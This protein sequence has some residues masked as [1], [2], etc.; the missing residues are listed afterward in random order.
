MPKNWAAHRRAIKWILNNKGNS[1]T[2]NK[3]S[4]SEC[5]AGN[6]QLAILF[7]IPTVKKPLKSKSK[8]F[9]AS[10]RTCGVL[11]FLLQHIVVIHIF[12]LLLQWTSRLRLPLAVLHRHH[13]EA[14]GHFYTMCFLSVATLLSP[15]LLLLLLFFL[16]LSQTAASPHLS[17][18]LSLSLSNSAA[19]SARSQETSLLP[20][21]FTLRGQMSGSCSWLFVPIARVLAHVTLTSL[22]P[23]SQIRSSRAPPPSGGGIKEKNGKKKNTC[24]CTLA[25]S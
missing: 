12:I 21:Y 25:D 5:K 4:W 6:F 18:L 7:G 23:L 17:S 24:T 15:S 9:K 22:R 20:V 13:S 8:T 3:T 14:G 16:L 2:A 10:V 19:L 11:L 1:D